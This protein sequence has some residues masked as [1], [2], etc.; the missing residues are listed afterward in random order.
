MINSILI[1]PS[2]TSENENEK[3]VKIV[4]LLLT[5]VKC[6]SV[7]TGRNCR[8]CAYHGIAHGLRFCKK[9]LSIENCCNRFFGS[10]NALVPV[11]GKET[12]ENDTGYMSLFSYTLCIMGGI[13]SLIIVCLIQKRKQ[14]I[15]W[16]TY[17]WTMLTH[18]KAFI[19]SPNPR[20]MA[21]KPTQKTNENYRT[22][23]EYRTL[24][25]RVA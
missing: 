7:C 15:P 4:F 5:L 14:V 22:L 16:V 6:G 21:G 20:K 12:V 24:Q 18:P 23:K 13:V 9:L 1:S 8:V 3:M 11:V 25:E 10:M 19:P 17:Y 2:S